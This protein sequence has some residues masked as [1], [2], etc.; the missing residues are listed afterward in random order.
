MGLIDPLN[1]QQVGLKVVAGTGTQIDTTT[2]N[3]RLVFGI[4]ASLAALEAERIRERT[5]A[6]LRAARARGRPGGSPRKMTAPTLT[7]AMTA[8]AESGS[9]AKE[10]AFRLGITTSTL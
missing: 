4:F 7:M 1:Q 5:Q 9:Q 2:A 8:L 6:G 3:G 10:V